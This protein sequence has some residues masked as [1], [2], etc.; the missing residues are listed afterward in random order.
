MPKLDLET[1]KDVFNFW[2]HEP[3]AFTRAYDRGIIKH[4]WAVQFVHQ[5]IL[6]FGENKKKG[7][8]V[9]QDKKNY[10]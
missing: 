10:R 8:D 5:M 1:V 2:Y 9:W 6:S 3:D 7:G 4:T